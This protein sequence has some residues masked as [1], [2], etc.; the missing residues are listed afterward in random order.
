MD[1]MEPMEPAAPPPTKAVNP[2][3]RTNDCEILI[4]DRENT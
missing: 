3:E 1:R 4:F 2:A